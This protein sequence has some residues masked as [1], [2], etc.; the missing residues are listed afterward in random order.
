MKLKMICNLKKKLKREI[1]RLIFFQTIF[2]YI[3]LATYK[4]Y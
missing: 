4:L 1:N 2:S 3:F